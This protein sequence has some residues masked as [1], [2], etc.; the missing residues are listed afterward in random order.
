LFRLAKPSWKLVG[1]LVV[2]G[3]ALLLIESYWFM[4]FVFSQSSLGYGR[5]INRGLFPSFATLSHAI[6]LSEP[7]WTGKNLS[8]FIAMPALRWNFALP[9]FAILWMLFKK[10]P[11]RKSYLLF[12]TVIGLIGM[13]LVKQA[14]DPFPSVYQWL[15]IHVPGFSLFRES[16]KFN[17]ISAMGLS[18]LVTAS[19]YI[20]K[21]RYK[22]LSISLGGILALIMLM[23][24][25]PFVN[26]SI[27]SLTIPR[28]IPKQYE[29][30][31]S[32]FDKDTTYG[33]SLWVPSA[34]RFIPLSADHPRISISDMFSTSWFN[35]TKDQETPLSLLSEPYAKALLNFGSFTTIGAP[36]DTINDIYRWTGKPQEYFDVMIAKIPDLTPSML[37]SSTMRIWNNPNAKPHAYIANNVITVDGPVTDFSG[38]DP[39]TDTAFV[40]KPDISTEIF[41]RIKDTIATNQEMIPFALTNIVVN[42]DSIST[43]SE[44]TNTAGLTSTTIPNT[45]SR[46]ASLYARKASDSITIIARIPQK[47]EVQI[48]SITSGPG[49]YALD[50]NG[51]TTLFVIPEESPEDVYIGIARLFPTQNSITIFNQTS[52]ATLIPNGSFEQGAWGPI[53]DCNNVGGTPVEENGISENISDKASEGLHGLELSAQKHVACLSSPIIA[54]EHADHIIGSLDYQYQQGSSGFADII[55]PTSSPS[56]LQS[57]RFAPIPDWQHKIF[58]IPNPNKQDLSLFLYQ[59]SKATSNQPSSGIF[60]NVSLHAYT[61]ITSEIFTVPANLF[62][63]E[64]RAFT[65]DDLIIPAVDSY[66]KHLASFDLG[67]CN[68]IDHTSLQKNGIFAQITSSSDDFSAISLRA[69]RHIACLAYDVPVS[70]PAFDYIA[71]IT[72]KTIKGATPQLSLASSDSSTILRENVP[73]SKSWNTYQVLFSGKDI[74]QNGVL[75][76]ALDATATP[77]ETLI[78]S[79]VLKKVPILPREYIT[80]HNSYLPNIPTV[81]KKINQST[82]EM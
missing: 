68:N 54:P 24:I 22:S 53:G 47:E 64:T 29:S 66:T 10:T 75:R 20:L 82:Y 55:S 14:N 69:K 48:T 38:N 80:S 39:S 40:F 27:G 58:S 7:F 31:T 11:L 72:Y 78:R 2:V 18:I 28:N 1:I 15:F 19:H 23:N 46:T 74:G 51:A 5:L 63:E 34:D 65:N 56:T 13:F 32:F 50:I 43:T 4:P 59:P 76:V 61:K 79:L 26:G 21:K 17:I 3:I 41:S 42:N 70:D 12:W 9:L 67:D 36:Y 57:I 35:F 44:I 77:A 49:A 6:S 33:R 8:D 45:T 30:I 60:D 81:F 71:E 52:N 37:S 16:S 62:T 25:I 73:P